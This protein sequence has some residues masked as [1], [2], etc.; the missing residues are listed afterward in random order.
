MDT[1]MSDCAISLDERD[2][3]IQPVN[4]VAGESRGKM[5]EKINAGEKQIF[6]RRWW[7]KY[8]VRS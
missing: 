7:Q 4:S 5:D 8:L 1:N 2:L 6:I 3:W